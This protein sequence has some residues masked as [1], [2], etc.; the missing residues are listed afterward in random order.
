MGPKAGAVTLS[1][2][3]LINLCL[4][5]SAWALP[6]PGR[7]ERQ[8][9]DEKTQ[10]P[11]SRARERASSKQAHPQG[12]SWA[13]FNRFG[14]H[15]L[16]RCSLSC[17]MANPG[18]REE[19]QTVADSWVPAAACANPSGRAW[20]CSPCAEGWERFRLAGRLCSS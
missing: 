6:P 11:E 9:L 17:S 5:G 18:W 7:D 19:S 12:P 14:E 16:V 4:A 20:S 8:R 13:S 1:S 10:L 2:S 15:R 3:S